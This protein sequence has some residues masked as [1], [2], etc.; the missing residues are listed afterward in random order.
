MK[1]K[2]LN[3]FFW[4]LGLC[5]MFL[6][7]VLFLEYKLTG[8]LL[9][10]SGLILLPVVGYFLLTKNIIIKQWLKIVIAVVLFFLAAVAT[11]TES[12]NKLL[13]NNENKELE[14]NENQNN[15]PKET[16]EEKLV[17]LTIEKKSFIEECNE[18]DYKEIFRNSNQYKGKQAKFT[19][20]VI[21]VQESAYGTVLR[22]NITKD[23]SYS[24]YY[25][26]TI[27]VIYT[28]IA[29]SEDPDAINRILEED[30]ITMYGK[31][32]DVETY[33]TILG[34]SVTIPRFIASYIELKK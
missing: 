27:Y 16:E 28:G 2:I 10:L 15:T 18:Y 6:G 7:M 13:D 4:M 20:E 29:K 34:G 33:E 5:L 32:D 25:T 22:V 3:L 1:N 21:Q 14:I 23:S 30:I 31:L 8:I 26:D 12:E 9:V 24:T 17:R 19:G 11:P